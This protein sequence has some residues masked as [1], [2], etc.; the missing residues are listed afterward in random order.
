MK[1]VFVAVALSAVSMHA[2]A[3]PAL[4]DTLPDGANFATQNDFR[5]SLELKSKKDWVQLKSGE[6][7]VGEIEE[8]FEEELV[9][10]SDD[11]G[12]VE[13]D[14]EDIE[15]INSHSPQTIYLR[16]R[17]VFYGALTFDNNRVVI[18]D[19]MF[20]IEDGELVSI[21]RYAKEERDRWDNEATLSASLRQGNTENMELNAKLSAIRTANSSRVR[22][23]YMGS[24]KRSE[25][26]LDS[27]SHRFTGSYNIYSDS[28]RFI[29]PVYIDMLHAYA[30][31]IKLQTSVGSQI[32]YDIYDSPKREWE[33]SIGPSWT[34]V[35]FDETEIGTPNQDSG[36]GVSLTSM[37][38]TDLKKD[39]E[40]SH[41]YSLTTSAENSGGWKHHNV[42]TLDIELTEI[43]DLDVDFIW[44][45]T[46]NPQP[47]ASGDSPEK[48]DY[49]L[50]VGLGV[51]F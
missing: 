6:I 10:D 31:N 19:Q 29:R 12:D 11:L 34:R 35:R 45:R 21:H 32:G 4:I 2:A 28:R 18:G 13:I 42:L 23:L 3:K 16:N 15:R 25:G 40:L 22:M 1:N 37:F 41:L 49:R 14:L 30:Q 43:I 27:R 39:V 20:D 50:S 24:F 26:S 36:F 51:E 46:Q 44:D 38:S 9:F 47:T 17:G 8:L 7:L 48:N 33:V 5:D